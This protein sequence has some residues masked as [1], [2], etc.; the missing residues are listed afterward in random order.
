MLFFS[1]LSSLA[2]ETGL[3]LCNRALND[4]EELYR[5]V[6][7]RIKQNTGELND[8]SELCQKVTRLGKAIREKAVHQLEEANSDKDEGTNKGH[9]QLSQYDVLTWIGT[10]TFGVT[11]L[12]RHRQTGLYYCMKIMSKQRIVDLKQQQHVRA[13]RQVLSMVKHPF[14]CSLFSSFQDD[15]SLYLVMDYVQ[16][17]ELFAHI[18]ASSGGL[19]ESTVRFYAAEIVLALEYLHSYKIVHRDLKPENLLLDKRGHIRVVDFGFSKIIEDKTFTVCGTPEYIAG[20]IISGRGHGMAVDYWSLGVL[21][22]EMLSGQPPFRGETNYQLFEVILACKYDMPPT[23]SH[24]AASLIR[25]LLQSDPTRRLGAMKGGMEEIKSHP[26]F[27]LVDWNVVLAAD[28]IGPL[29][30]LRTTVEIKAP[31]GPEF[32]NFTS[33]PQ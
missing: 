5:F 16:G 10:G 28:T 17:G 13:E 29:G 19:P 1:F 27:N 7:G 15:Y 4:L 25:G 18:R 26:F 32:A 20:E 6:N 22:F 31:P 21:L 9:T 23:F 24:E 30:L 3:S 2:Q 14:L 8:I 11:K 12:C 33:A